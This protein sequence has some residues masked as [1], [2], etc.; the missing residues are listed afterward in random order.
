MR[1]DIYTDGSIKNN[2]KPDSYGG[3]ASILLLYDL[4]GQIIRKKEIV[5][6]KRDTTNNEME[7]MGV[8]SGLIA[9]KPEWAGKVPITVYSDSQYCTN[10]FSKWA[11]TWKRMG[12]RNGR[13]EVPNNLDLIKQG[14]DLTQQFKVKYV[15]VKGHASNEWNNEADRLAGEE[16]RKL[17]PR[18]GIVKDGLRKNLAR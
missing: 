1:V 18:G 7:L 10:T 4:D 14:Y 9:L 5:G 17:G 12:W 2:G 3:W 16:M 13:N 6:S 15:W 11:R 8:V